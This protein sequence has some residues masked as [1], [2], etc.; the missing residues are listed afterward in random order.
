MTRFTRACLYMNKYSHNTTVAQGCVPQ[1]DF[2]EDWWNESID[3]IEEKLFD[4]YNIPENIRKFIRENI[5]HK[6]E[7]NIVCLDI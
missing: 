7:K 5:Q 6:T 2:S 3:V 1:Q 4:K